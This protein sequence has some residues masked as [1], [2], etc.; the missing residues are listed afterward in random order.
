[1]KRVDRPRGRREAEFHLAS[2]ALTLAELIG[3]FP[4]GSG[5]SAARRASP[6]AS[7]ASSRSR[8]SPARGCRSRRPRGPA[9][10]LREACS[11]TAWTCAATACTPL[12]RRFGFVPQETFL[13]STTLAA[14]IAFGVEEKDDEAIHEAAARR[15][16]RSRRRGLPQGLRDASSASAASLSRAGRSSAPPSRAR[17]HAPP[18]D[19]GARRLPLVGRHLHRGGDPARADAGDAEP[20]LAARL[21]PRLDRARTPTR[22]SSSTRAGSPSAAPTRSCWPP[23]ASTP[24]SCASSSSRRSSRPPDVSEIAYHE[25]EALG[26]AYDARLMRRLLGFLAALQAARSRWP[27]PSCWPAPGSR[28]SSPS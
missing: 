17:R 25:E 4:T 23:A 11:S 13:F 18:V 16:P 6:A 15:P 21:A 3:A 10:G 1:M 20:H 14:N 9:P 19:P 7:A 27:W 5:A 24:S 22:S 8:R 26:R 2:N 12:R 28:S